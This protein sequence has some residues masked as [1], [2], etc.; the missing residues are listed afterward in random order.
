MQQLCSA[1][2]QSNTRA[3]VTQHQQHQH[4]I[5]SGSI[6]QLYYELLC[7]YTHFQCAAIRIYTIVQVWNV[8]GNWE[9]DKTLAQHQRWVWDAAFSADSNY[10]VTASSD[11]SAKLWELR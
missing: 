6:V 9:L 3:L 4:S 2:S 7:T 10:L 1:Q 8:G 11:H 5:V